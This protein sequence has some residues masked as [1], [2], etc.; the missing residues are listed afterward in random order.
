MAATRAT[1]RP[2]VTRMGGRLLA[3]YGRRSLV[4][5]PRRCLGAKAGYPSR[6]LRTDEAT[7]RGR[8]SEELWAVICIRADPDV[9][10]QGGKESRASLY[11]LSV[12]LERAM[13]VRKTTRRRGTEGSSR[14]TPGGIMGWFGWTTR[15]P[16][17][18]TDSSPSSG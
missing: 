13:A 4:D 5:P 3:R 10:L 1:R 11:A 8:G 18:G 17:S 7:H 16:E 9:V 12:L 2:R 14:L 6:G 15:G